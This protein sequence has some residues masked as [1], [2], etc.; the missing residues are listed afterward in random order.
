ML[1]RRAL[2]ISGAGAAASPAAAWASVGAPA[3]LAAA[4]ETDGRHALFGLTAA[5]GIAFRIPLPERGHAAA[6]HPSRAEAV[7]IARRPG[8]FALAVDCAAG[9]VLRR[10]EP[11]EGRRFC[12]HGAYLHS[13][14]A[15][16]TT[17]NAF[18]TGEGRLGLWNVRKGYARIGEIPSGGVGPHEVINLP[19]GD[20]LAVANGGIRTH[21]DSGRKK[22][23]LDTM[24]PNLSYVQD[25]EIQEIVELP[26]PKLSIRHLSARADGTLAMGLQS[27]RDP[28]LEVPMVAVHKRGE[29]ARLLGA[30]LAPS[31]RGYVGSVAWS[32]DGARIAATAPRGGRAAIWTGERLELL[33]RPDICGV[34]PAGPDLAF[35][36]GVGGVLTATGAKKHSVAWD[37]HLAP[38][39]TAKG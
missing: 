18:E 25:G 26:D 6:A 38:I 24:R 12:G 3:F 30:E 11:P 33:H 1:S 35:T 17:E 4:R 32:G 21:P 29:V 28:I 16:V 9:R 15:F 10:L 2:L 36:D 23:N 39:H 27:E 7:A 31:F 34:A 22:L 13:G 20:I 14:E 8:R 5:G 19:G 37:N